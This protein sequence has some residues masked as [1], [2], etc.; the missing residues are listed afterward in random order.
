[1]VI[2]G[3]AVLIS[4][5]GL[6]LA[7]DAVFSSLATG[8]IIVVAIAVLGS[9]TVLP[10]LLSKLG[11]AIDRPRMPVLWRLTSQTRSPRLWPALLRPSL[12]RPGRTFPSR[13]AHW[14][15]WRCRP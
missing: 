4:M 9:L 3:L 5:V 15:R 7:D 10:A 6:Y 2:S 11:R 8:S 12:D 1:M 14:S 13:W